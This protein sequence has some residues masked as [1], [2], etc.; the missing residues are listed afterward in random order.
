MKIFHLIFVTFVLSSLLLLSPFL[1]SSSFAQQ[2]DLQNKDRPTYT[3]SLEPSTDMS[4]QTLNKMKQKFDSGFYDKTIQ[5]LNAKTDGKLSEFLVES[6]SLKSISELPTDEQDSYHVILVVNKHDDIGRDSKI[7]VKE[8]KERLADILR[9][10]HG[11]TNIYVAEKLSFVSA[12]I[13]VSEIPKLSNYENDVFRVGDGE[14]NIVTL[15]ANMEVTK[16]IVESDDVGFSEIFPY[17]G[18]GVRVAVI[19]NTVTDNHLDLPYGIDEA[20]VKFRCESLTTEECTDLEGINPIQDEEHHSTRVAGIIAGRGNIETAMQGMAPESNVINISTFLTGTGVDQNSD[21]EDDDKTR[22]VMSL[23][24]ALRQGADVANLSISPGTIC[25]DYN[26]FS[27]LVDEAVDQGL[28]MT[29]A[30]GN[31]GGIWTISCGYNMISTGAVFDDGSYANSWVCGTSTCSSSTGPAQ[32]GIPSDEGY[33]PPRMKPELVA[34]GIDIRT[35]DYDNGYSHDSGTSFASP[36]VAG[37]AALIKDIRAAPWY[38]PLETKVVLLLGADW[39]P[40]NV[41]T[42]TEYPLTARDY[43]TLEGTDPTGDVYQTLNKYGFGLLNVEQSLIYATT[44]TPTENHII[45]DVVPQNESKNYTFEVTSSEV[46]QPTKVILSWLSQPLDR[47]GTSGFADVPVSNLDFIIA[48]PTGTVFVNS[49]SEHQN[50]EFAVFTPTEEGIYTITVSGVS[51]D[52]TFIQNER[53]VIASTIQLDVPGTNQLPIVDPF[54]NDIAIEDFSAEYGP[55]DLWLSATD[56]NN[57]ILSFYIVEEPEEGV[58]SPPIKD[59]SSTARVIYQANSDFIGIDDFSFKVYDGKGQAPA[60]A[61]IKVIIRDQ[62]IFP[63]HVVA[64]H[65]TV[66]PSID[67]TSTTTLDEDVKQ[68]ATSFASP[69]EPV[70]GLYGFSTVKA[71]LQFDSSPTSFVSLDPD[72]GKLITFTEPGGVSPTNIQ[73][74]TQNTDETDFVTIGYEFIETTVPDPPTILTATAISNSQINLSWTAP[75][76]NGGSEI[77][78][79]KIERE[80]PNG[81][82]FTIIGPNTDPM[83]TTFSDVGLFPETQYNYRVSAIN[84]V[85]FSIPSNEDS[86]TTLDLSS[87]PLLLH[88]EFDGNVND[89]STQDNHGTLTGTPSFPPGKIGQAI[90]LDG[91]TY[92]EVPNQATYDF[93]SGDPFSIALWFKGSSGTSGTLVAKMENA[94]P[95]RGYDVYNAD[96]TIL[97]QLLNDANTPVKWAEISSSINV[98]DGSWHHIV[99]TYDGSSS[100]ETGMQLYIDG[101]RDDARTVTQDSLAGTISQTDPVTVGSRVNGAVPVTGQLDDLRIY[102][103]VLLQEQIDDLIP[104]PPANLLLTS[105]TSTVLTAGS[106]TPITWIGGDTSSEIKISIIDI[107]AWTVAQTIVSSTPN[108]GLFTYTIPTT[109]PFDGPCERE[110]QFYIQNSQV[111]D[112]NYGPTF[113]IQCE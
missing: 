48:D 111:T 18:K 24:F 56:T 44:N 5:L 63:D 68:I 87:P 103:T 6:R 69:T 67:D 43:E 8:N 107:E 65:S 109:L 74:V 99:A 64:H 1:L 91:S 25:K 78:G 81:N 89:S 113:T 60:G 34:P 45:R 66:P 57:D 29:T 61:P 19:D 79:Y 30:A 23:D 55:L 106:I 58:L 40:Q 10:N 80:S 15:S 110:Y 9:N 36:I 96:G 77:T 51:V 22:L 100:A 83:F 85:G 86:A 41:I 73:I 11:A 13:P 14:G 4:S 104:P 37:A 95:F 102:G 28:F 71:T 90:E 52:G 105:P 47:G 92:V 108:D 76:N 50:N 75:A 12:K 26:V 42:S 16:S 94:A 46:N 38:T 20:L 59:T 97:F 54:D 33:I 39:D 93:D 21:G 72:S 62:N 53:F 2:S 35:L 32:F 3:P 27:I 17:T 7:V 49:N 70:S 84:G 98:N 82:G 112:W 31:G 101:V 88:Y